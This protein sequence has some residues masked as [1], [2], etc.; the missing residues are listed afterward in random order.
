M[1]RNSESGFTLIE[2]MLV[3]TLLTLISSVATVKYVN[4]TAKA[5]DNVRKDTMAA[6]QTAL[7]LYFADNGK[8]PSTGTPAPVYRSSEPGDPDY[9]ANWIPGLVP[10]YM[11]SLPHDPKGG[12]S[13]L[14]FPA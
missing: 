5:R 4:L 12:D 8:Y 7:D 1:N 2:L 3:V 13:T 11:S 14:N 9:S 6:I 10:K